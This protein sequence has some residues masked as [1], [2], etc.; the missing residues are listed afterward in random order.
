MLSQSNTPKVKLGGRSPFQTAPEDSDPLGKS[1]YSVKTV[2][3]GKSTHP[4]MDEVY[5]DYNT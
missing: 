2:P 5:Q 3:G 4:A 1:R